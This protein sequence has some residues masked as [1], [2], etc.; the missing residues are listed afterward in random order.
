[1]FSPLHPPD[2]TR[3]WPTCLCAPSG[4]L[5][6]QVNQARARLQ[7][8]GLIVLDEVHY[9]G[10]PDR[11]SVWEEVIIHCP[12]H[13][14]LL[15]MSATTANPEDLG[16]WIRAVHGPCKNVT[17]GFRPVPLTW[18]YCQEASPGPRFAPNRMSAP[19]SCLFKCLL[20]I[21]CPGGWVGLHLPV[22]TPRDRGQHRQHKSL[23][24]RR[25]TSVLLFKL[26]QWRL[27]SI[28]NLPQFGDRTEVVPLLDAS[29]RHL[30]RELLIGGGG[31][32]G[33]Q[34]DWEVLLDEI[35]PDEYQ[36]P[37]G[38]A[39]GKGRWEPQ[40]PEGR[41]AG[42]GRWGP[43]GRSGGRGSPRG[44][45]RYPGPEAEEVRARVGGQPTVL[46][47]V[48][49][50][51]SR[52]MLPAIWFIFSRQSCDQTATKLAADGLV[53]T[54]AQ[55]QEQIREALDQLRLEQPEVLRPP[56]FVKAL[57]AGIAAHHAGCL[58]AWKASSC[59]RTA[60][61]LSRVPTPRTCRLPLQTLMERL[62]QRG[63]L[64]LVFATDTLA[65]G[66]NMPARTTVISA[67][68]RR[69]GER[70]IARLT[71]N[72]L[73]QMAG[74]AGRRGFDTVGNC[75]VI[76]SRFEGPADALETVVKVGP[77]AKPAAAIPIP[78]STSNRLLCFVRLFP[79]CLSRAPS[80]CSPSSVPASG[81]C[82]PCCS[83]VRA[84][85]RPGRPSSGP[86]GHI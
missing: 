4:L 30:S 51:R 69:R 10:D 43:R 56:P 60:V 63:L 46:D 84:S 27:K 35:M 50:L 67:L 49:L 65:A 41:G 36:L 23:S 26:V 22:Y 52:E 64:K 82:C 62:F 24:P 32:G 1:M 9:L 55:E 34:S 85:R 83:Q 77:P 16:G 2:A 7:D 29:G 79:T 48:S 72:E 74:R 21:G 40:V 20:W 8:V 59:R 68:S 5:I 44:P 61:P 11:G 47:A 17:T 80:R 15:C 71:H 31:G 39:K 37:K 18:Y 3:R 33:R 78:G 53:L 28:S 57:I 73:M 81:W 19:V 38:K 6:E 70:G 14:Q 66:I 75:V 45:E 25:G 86:S 58:P 12:E 54:T 42:G 76:K 13:V